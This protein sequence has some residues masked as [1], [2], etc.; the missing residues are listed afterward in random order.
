MKNY[1][2]DFCCWTVPAENS[3]EAYYKALRHL[4]EGKIPRVSNH[5]DYD[6][7]NDSP[8]TNMDEL[9]SGDWTTVEDC[10]NEL[11]KGGH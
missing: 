1:Y 5:D 10:K 9:S 8:S 7:Y 2:I 11:K 4:A 3:T 6:E